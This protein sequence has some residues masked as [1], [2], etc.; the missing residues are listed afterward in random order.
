[1][2]C[3]S[4]DDQPKP[5][6]F[7]GHDTTSGAICYAYYYLAKHPACLAAARRELDAVFGPDPS[8]VP[9]QLKKDPH[10]INKLEYTLAVMREVLR[11][12]PPASTIRTA[13]KDFVLRH[14]ETGELLPT[15]GFMLWAVD[16][17]IGRSEAYWRDAHAF[18]PERFLDHSWNKDAWIPFSKG[19]RNCIGQELAIIES[20]IILAMTLREFDV[21]CAFAEVERLKGD[22]TPYPCDTKGVQEQFGEEMYQIQLGTA[23]PREGMPCRVKARS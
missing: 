13:P 14:P 7:A 16:T 5:Q 8:T 3:T 19:V 11:L 12:Q 15:D 20:R 21:E 2:T 17:G 10:L 4:A 6:L 18:R 23:K 1:M 22:G 9:A